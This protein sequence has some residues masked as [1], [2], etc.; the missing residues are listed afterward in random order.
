M[1]GLSPVGPVHPDIVSVGI[2]LK[3]PAKFAELRPMDR[4]VAVSFGL[5]RVARHPLITRKVNA[6]GPRLWHVANV[7]AADDVDDE[8]IGLLAEAYRLVARS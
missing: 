5:A 6:Y 8:L 7:P 2:F 4:W 3:N 1:Q